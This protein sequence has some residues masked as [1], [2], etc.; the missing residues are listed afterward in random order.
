MARK[1][2]GMVQ[3]IPNWRFLLDSHRIGLVIKC[4]FIHGFSKIFVSMGGLNSGNSKPFSLSLNCHFRGKITR[5]NCGIFQDS[6]YI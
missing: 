4:D 2:P 3:F 5:V 1:Y 6:S